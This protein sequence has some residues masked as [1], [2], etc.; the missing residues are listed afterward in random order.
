MTSAFP[1]LFGDSSSGPMRP[2]REEDSGSVYEYSN[3]PSLKAPSTPQGSAKGSLSGSGS[4]S[5][6]SQ[7]SDRLFR[8]STLMRQDED[9]YTKSSR[10]VERIIQQ[11]ELVSSTKVIII[12]LKKRLLEKKSQFI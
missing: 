9:T 10:A 6:R 1:G 8:C 12:Q 11:A 3:F 2:I 7:G 5:N 4:G